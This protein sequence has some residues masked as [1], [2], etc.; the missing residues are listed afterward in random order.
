MTPMVST[1]KEYHHMA[2]KA[3]HR[4]ALGTILGA[5]L[6]LHS[7]ATAGAPPVPAKVVT[8]SANGSK[9]DDVLRD[10]FG[11]VGLKVKVSSLVN[12][13]MNGKW[14][15]PA[16]QLWRM[17]ATT[18]NL[19]S[20]Y[21]GGVTRIYTASELKS[22]IVPTASPSDVVREANR[23]GLTDANNRVSAGSSNVS[24][25]GVPEFVRRIE[26]IAGR[27]TAPQ[28]AVRSSPPPLP[29]A[30]TTDTSGVISPSIKGPAVGT[31]PSVAAAPPP[32]FTPVAQNPF[33][34]PQKL[35]YEVQTR[36]NSRSPYEVRVYYLNYRDPDDEL[37]N[38][39]GQ[40]I[41]YP[42][43]AS[44]LR[45]VMGDGRRPTARMTSRPSRERP[46]MGS[47]DYDRD[48][49][50]DGQ[51]NDQPQAQDRFVG[52]VNGPRIEADAVNRSVIIRDRPEAMSQYEAIIIAN[53]IE[54]PQITV[55][56][57]IIELNI[58][59]LKQ[60]GFS[61][62][63]RT[64]GLNSLLS[65]TN[66][67]IG[68][69][70]NAG[71]VSFGVK[72]KSIDISARLDALINNGSLKVVSKPQIIAR[73][74]KYSEYSDG[75]SI[76][77]PV[78]GERVTD[79]DEKKAGLFF[80]VKPNVIRGSDP[81]ST[82]LDISIEDGSIISATED[83]QIIRSNASVVAQAT[84]NQGESIIIG[85]MVRS[86]EYSSRS[87]SALP[88][89]GEILQNKRSG[90]Q[91][92]ERLYMIT[93]RIYAAATSPMARAAAAAPTQDP[94]VIPLEVLQ[95]KGQGRKS[96]GRR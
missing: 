59:R 91:R 22:A 29:R 31:K 24:V 27:A 46:R 62:D 63:V 80:R 39:N 10:L 84:V 25:T 36:P 73:N 16:N 66:T 94:N 58:T 67:A 2:R 95:G 70:A 28:V 55:E 37:I 61:I 64:G 13:P 20:Y 17:M 1:H 57:T 47:G 54:Q 48:Y 40:T 18:H 76:S 52:D 9:A 4:L 51:N 68:G 38:I 15:V 5:A 87:K 77:T 89:V 42:G 33:G 74:N 75:Q 69:S 78:R 45:G 34:S 41:T 50:D 82:Q 23:L 81:L 65:T 93:P 19:V 88:V 92:T 83:G 96:G 53:D 14:T 12:A 79:V 3:L 11:Q 35:R 72:G 30:S 71:G 90:G 86:S 26:D 6:L 56:A 49:D 60:L 21:E 8:I 44:I 7:P 85:G 43:V 32:P